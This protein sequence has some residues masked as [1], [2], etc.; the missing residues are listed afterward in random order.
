MS[1]AAGEVL[2]V[3]EVPVSVSDIVAMSIATRDFHPIHHDVERAR[4]AGHP[5]L[6]LNLMS[7]SGLVE[8]FVRQWAG[9]GARLGR[10]AFR[11]GI[12]HYAG[13]VLRIEGHVTAN[14]V[15]GAQRW[16]DIEFKANNPRGT[17]ASGQ[18]RVIWQ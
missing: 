9:P 15:Q 13:E 12:P 10:L 16:A 5:P 3:L 18:V 2:P 11:L 6:F 17:H 14:G 4:A 1:T 7:T 8:R